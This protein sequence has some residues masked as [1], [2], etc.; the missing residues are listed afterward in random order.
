MDQKGGCV[1][2]IRHTGNSMGVERAAMGVCVDQIRNLWTSFHRAFPITGRR[3]HGRQ[4]IFL[5]FKNFIA[6]SQN[7]GSRVRLR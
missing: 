5:S 1:W 2:N 4:G 7:K 6:K 3:Y